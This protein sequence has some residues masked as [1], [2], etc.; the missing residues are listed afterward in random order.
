MI[1]SSL[2]SSSSDDSTGGGGNTATMQSAIDGLLETNMKHTNEESTTSAARSIAAPPTVC[3]PPAVDQW[4]V[5]PDQ[6]FDTAFPTALEETTLN[7]VVVA[8]HINKPMNHF[9]SPDGSSIQKSVLKRKLINPMLPAAQKQLC[10]V[11][12]KRE[13]S[14]GMVC[15][16]TIMDSKPAV[17][18]APLSTKI[19]S[20][21]DSGKTKLQYK[22]DICGRVCSNKT[23]LTRHIRTHTGEK[24]YACDICG[25]KF[26]RKSNVYSH[27]RL[28]HEKN[29]A[30]PSSASASH[31]P[32]TAGFLS[33]VQENSAAGAAFALDVSNV[34]PMDGVTS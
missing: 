28:V 1:V 2:G 5:K 26:N 25:K 12:A 34:L 19:I 16:V 24:P 22:C 20:V 9:K 7:D 6:I 33:L 10:S 15:P 3:D 13:S 14:A 4:F 8:D 30:P 17:E 32:R 31:E 23:D 11:V 21:L 18:I 27:K 29:T